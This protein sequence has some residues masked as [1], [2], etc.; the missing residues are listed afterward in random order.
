LSQ[1][2]KKSLTLAIVPGEVWDSLSDLGIDAVWL[3]GVWER[4]PM[5]I[6]IVNQNAGI[7]EDLHKALPD[8]KPEDNVGS[9]YCIKQFIA[10]DHFGGREGL[11]VA[12]KELSMR[13]IRLMLDFVPNHLAPDHPWVKQH[14]EFIIQGTSEDIINDNAS[15][16]ETE[17]K[18]FACGRDP[19]FPAWPDVIQLN[20]FHP[21]LRK[22]AV[23]T[24][25]DIAGQ[26]DG[27]RCDMA[28]LLTNSVFQ[29]TWGKHAG[30][31]PDTEYWI[32]VISAIKKLYPEFL[33]MAEAYWDMEWELQQQGFDYCYDKR[34]Y[35]R[36]IN[37]SAEGVLIHLGGDIGY[38][39]K[40]VRFIENHDEPRASAVFQSRKERA[41]AIIMGTIPGARLFHEG[42]F[43]GRQ[44]KLPVFLGRRPD[45]PQNIYHKVFYRT[46]LRA[47]TKKGI[48]NG[49]WQIL[50][51]TGWTDNNTWQNILA[52]SYKDFGEFYLVIINYS[53]SD[54]QA[55][56]QLP[57]EEL[58][59]K[60]WHMSDL[61]TGKEYERAGDELFNQGL[62]VDLPSWGYHFMTDLRKKL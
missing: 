25:T 61:F 55:M 11:A 49:H 22:A 53:G 42:Q 1:R 52:W 26:C 12:R 15:F 41:A 14:P 45:E 10:D 17:G 20:A 40:L 24:V 9:P 4:S 44:V 58:K 43:E 13:G 29:K 39:E 35:D 2:Y 7:L 46:L 8:Y 21:G 28:M 51:R 38:Q 57:W 30:E 6:S 34:L 31:M 36:L 47:I 50:D 23:V 37:D 60:M 27:I 59:G 56:I 32:E 62:F 54:A 33:F 19:F 3:M 5:G 16:I 48:R 18:I